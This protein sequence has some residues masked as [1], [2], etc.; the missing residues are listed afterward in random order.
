MS[1]S[2]P[3]A[4]DAP[5]VIRSDGSLT[6]SIH[7]AGEHIGPYELSAPLGAGGMA[8]VWKAIDR[9]A[10]RTVALKVLPT[11]LARDPSHVARFKREA[12]AA[13]AL[14]HPAVAKAFQCGEWDGIHA[15]A[16]E[17]IPGE[18]LRQ[19]VDR[20]GLVPPRDAVA[21]LSD[22][23]AGLGH[24]ASRGVTHRDVKPS[25][26]MI[27]PENRAVLIDMGL[28][29]RDDA[30]PAN[31]GVTASGTTLGTFDYVSPEQALDPRTAD[32]RSDLYSLGCTFYHVLT[33]RPPVPE[34]TAARKLQAH[35]HE[36]PLDPRRLNPAISDDLALVLS[37]LMAKRPRDRYQTPAHLER[38][39]TVLTAQ[40]HTPPGITGPRLTASPGPIVPT[41]WL[42]AGLAVAAALAVVVS[43]TV[44]PRPASQSAGP[45]PAPAAA[46]VPV[47]DQAAPVTLPD[48][49]RLAATA[50]DFAT[51]LRENTPMIRLEP[52]REYDLTTAED[53]VF[54]GKSLI[55]ETAAGTAPAIVILPATAGALDGTPTVRG[56][57]AV[58]LRRLVVRTVPP[59]GDDGP[60]IEPCGIAFDHCASVTLTECRF[61]MYD[62]LRA[63]KAAAVAV[64]ADVKTELTVRS[65]YFPAGSVAFRL[66]GPVSATVSE[67]AFGPH[68]AVFDLDA[69][70]GTIALAHVTFLFRPDGGAA[71]DVGPGAAFVVT[72]GH[73]AFA[74]AGPPPVPAMMMG[75]R[76]VPVLVRADAAPLAMS[77]TAVA[78]E[79]NAY[80]R[81]DAAAIGETLVPFERRTEAKI[82]DAPAVVLTAPP[83]AEADPLAASAGPADPWRAFRLRLDVPAVRVPRD[84]VVGARHRTADGAVRV[85][86]GDWPPPRPVDLAA[87]PVKLWWPAAP[88]TE[89]LPRN[90]S[91]RLDDLVAAAKPGDVIE[92][93]HAGRLGVK[94]VRLAP[95][96]SLTIRAATGSRPVLV[97]DG[98]FVELTDGTVTLDGL[99]VRL[100]GRG[101]A[102]AV[103]KV[104]GAGSV[105]LRHC[106]VTTDDADDRV[107][108][109]ALG[110]VEADGRGPGPRVRFDE[111]LI[112]GTGRGVGV[113]TGRPFALEIV[114]SVL[115]IDG[116]VLTLD[117]PARGKLTLSKST[118]ALAGPLAEWKAG[119]PGA[120]PLEVESNRV[121]FAAVGPPPPLVVVD[122]GDGTMS[123]DRVLTWAAEACRYANWE[124][125]S[126][127]F[128][129]RP[130]DGT[131]P[132]RLDAD[133]WFR[134][135][136]REPGRALTRARSPRFPDSPRALAEAQ[137]TDFPPP[138]RSDS[139]APADP[140]GAD[141]ATLPKPVE[142]THPDPLR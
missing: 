71:F 17:F 141:P 73:C 79:P 142:S 116:P 83:W 54:T 12:R 78:G 40:L 119:R 24:A 84:V 122:G 64:S 49:F 112:R 114:N 1:P 41:S 42:A 90:A 138:R 113:T 128:E 9:D 109:V 95:D 118:L 23:A 46:D 55:V 115:A 70:R 96:A 33:G 62:G 100:T 74:A 107:A 21:Y 45:R 139:F 4:A 30:G 98:A 92:I 94:P 133:E 123:P 16:C 18:T 34:G 29:R 68:E 93:R 130:A 132:V 87:E 111:C 27:T 124:R 25:N 140:V 36:R 20:D 136:T 6:S 38:D 101:E 77:L 80:Y 39:L 134:Q 19:K 102:R 14:D 56:A 53:V 13:A 125:S 66:D 131:A 7:S 8:T 67:C 103:A 10:R 57:E 44:A 106:V 86:A 127:M 2:D 76:A 32:V 104:T 97:P 31:G 52:G 3:Y 121:F 61:E 135:I 88:E 47:A 75:G 51:L 26:V 15:I 110:G 105:T 60:V 126:T 59:P 22:L 48:G 65:C 69:G 129:I 91:R 108:V 63:G 120:V 37:R 11:E 58:E 43:P 5:T 99:D 117:A 72:A 137:P 81:V 28:A 85:Y 35:R 89:A 82:D 50:D